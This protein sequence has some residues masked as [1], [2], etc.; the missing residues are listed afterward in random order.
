MKKHASGVEL[1]SFA[2]LRFYSSSFV[3]LQ[4]HFLAILWWCLL[5][6]FM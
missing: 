6:L 4:I 3:I 1:H 2:I 5:F